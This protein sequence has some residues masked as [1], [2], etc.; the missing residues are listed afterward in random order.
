[1][2]QEELTHQI[3]SLVENAPGVLD[4]TSDGAEGSTI[5]K[6]TLEKILAQYVK[7]AEDMSVEEVTEQALGYKPNRK[8]RRKLKK[9]SSA[10]T[11]TFDDIAEERQKAVENL[12]NEQKDNLIL[13]LLEKVITINEN[14]EENNKEGEQENN[15]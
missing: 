6:E 14:K 7:Q 2:N 8:Q 4:S 15:D 9:Q 13:R 11:Q 5:N 12:T 3:E 1:M 10:L